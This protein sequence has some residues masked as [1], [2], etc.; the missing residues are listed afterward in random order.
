MQSAY[1]IPFARK[2]GRNS[3]NIP[4][5]DVGYRSMNL[6]IVHDHWSDYDDNECPID[7]DVAGLGVGSTMESHVFATFG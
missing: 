7:P 6:G 2:N 4:L 1:K 5:S 3:T